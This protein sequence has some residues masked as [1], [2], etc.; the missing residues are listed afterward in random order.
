[1]LIQNKLKTYRYEQV[2][3][4]GKWKFLLEIFLPLEQNFF[5]AMRK[6]SNEYFLQEHPLTCQKYVLFIFI[7]TENELKTL[8]NIF[9]NDVFAMIEAN[10]KSKIIKDLAIT[11]VKFLNLEE[12]P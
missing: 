10:S 4:N 2:G 5:D 7:V 11:I 12:T 9:S 3:K 8:C 1:M 6:Y